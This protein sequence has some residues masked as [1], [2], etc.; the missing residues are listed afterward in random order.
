M[1]SKKMTGAI[2]E[3]INKE[4]YSAYL[5]Q[6]MSAF[7]SYKGW[8][9]IANWFQIQ[10]QEELTHSQKFYNYVLDQGELVELAAIDKPEISFKT[11]LDLFEE[12]LKHEKIVTSLINSLM[13]LAQKE[14]DRATY[15]FLQ[16]FIDE[17]VEEEANAGDLVGQ[18][19]MIGNEGGGLFMFDKELSTRVFTP[20]AVN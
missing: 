7:A 20:P 16:W 17:Q 14:N 9:G 11:P 1:I 5:Y 2:N 19:K 10:V 12:T 6:A 8:K 3:Q 18:L 13:D 4:V 15:S